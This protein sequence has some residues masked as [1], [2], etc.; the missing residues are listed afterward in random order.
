ME[1]IEI[2]GTGS[3][4]QGVGRLSD[5]RV[6]FVP[7]AL[8]GETVQIEIISQSARYCSGRLCRVVRASDARKVPD[9]PSYAVC[10]GCQG[11]HMT[12]DATL[13]CKRQRVYD[14]LKRIGGVQSPNVLPAQGCD[15]PD[16]TRNKAEFPI[17]KDDCGRITIG[18]YASGSRRIVPLQDCLLQKEPACR[19]LGWFSE[20]LDE[21]RGNTHMTCLVARVSREDKL[22]LILCADAPILSDVKALIP[23]LTKA[24]PELQS[25]YFLRQNRHPA[26][27]LDG[28]CIHLWG[29]RALSERLMDLDFDV[30]PQS[31]F[32]VNREQAERLYASALDAAGLQDGT[33][34]RILDVYCGTGT[35]TLA[36]AKRAEYAVGVEIVPVAIDDA[37]INARR[38]HLAGR[39]RFLLGDAAREIPRLMAAEHFDAVILDPPRKG[40]DER[41][42]RAIIQADPPRIAYVSC[43][44]A[45]LARDVKILSAAGYHPDWAK[46]IDM[47]PWTEHVETVVQLSKE[48][49]K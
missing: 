2:T 14:A 46:P 38:N 47:F 5:G 35:I 24:L 37:R 34:K 9:C 6:V 15:N 20:H 31:F 4:L 32:Q 25:L 3:E 45:T 40:A 23:P 29:E 36:A 7:G 27:A 21:L 30:S 43:N 22:M 28:E 41:T 33:S 1:T 11:R 10:G 8:V 18:A 49:I 39:T 48:K 26:H 13:E 42:L 44:P 12:Y 17:G 19:A 16:R